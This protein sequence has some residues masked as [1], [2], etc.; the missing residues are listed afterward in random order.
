MCRHLWTP[1]VG[2]RSIIPLFWKG[3]SNGGRNLRH[4]T[5][6]KSRRNNAPGGKRFSFSGATNGQPLPLGEQEL[7]LATEQV[8]RLR[9]PE[10]VPGSF[11]FREKVGQ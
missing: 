10:I 4:Q 5:N 9:D 7:L 8:R 3:K 2:C 6:S 1:R 11:G